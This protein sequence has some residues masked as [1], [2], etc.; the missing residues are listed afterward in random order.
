MTTKIQKHLEKLRGIKRRSYH[1]LV[2]RIHKKYRIS[3]KT[4]FYIKEYGQHSNITKTIIK[5]S[6]KILLFASI[7]S[8]FGGLAL[9]QV[10]A[11]FISLVPLV[12]L[13]PTMND[14]IGN[15]STIISARFTTMLH[16]GKIKRNIYQNKEL[17]KLALQIFIIAILTALLSAAGAFFIS[18]VSGYI[19]TAEVVYKIMAIVLINVMLLV[20]LLFMLSLAAGLYFYRKKEDPNNFLIPITTSVADFGNMIILALLVIVLF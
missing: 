4:L 11:A 14:M 16:E 8:S 12:I 19:L 18:S 5:E 10:K 20:S 13:M 17:R 7:I 3:K 6:I 2:H 1:P 9:E 15:F